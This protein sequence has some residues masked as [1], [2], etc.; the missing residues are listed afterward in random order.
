MK[1]PFALREGLIIGI[2]EYL[3][4]D[5]DQPDARDLAEAVARGLVSSAEDCDIED[6]DEIIQQIEEA[7]ELE[8]SLTDTLE[9]SFSKSADLELTGEDVVMHT[10]KTLE[11]S[12][13]DEDLL[14]DMDDLDELPLSE[15]EEEEAL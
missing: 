6:A 2:D 4:D 15:T 10:E 8:E 14:D 1:L 12:W 7:G 5:N 3:E 11:L 9:D 13:T